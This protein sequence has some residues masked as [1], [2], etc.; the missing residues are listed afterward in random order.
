MPHIAVIIPYY[1]RSQGILRRALES[2]LAQKLPPDVAVH[3]IVVDDGS[4]APATPEAEGL[5]FISPFCLTVVRKPNVGVAA[6]RDEGLQR[7]D[8]STDYITFLDSD[9][10]W[11]PEHIAQAVTALGRGYDYYFTD[12]SR[13]G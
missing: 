13:V 7:A 5:S 11:E 6:A 4:P 12:H 2:I 9:D 1:Q 10:A 3:V 8:D